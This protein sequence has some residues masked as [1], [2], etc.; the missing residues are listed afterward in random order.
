MGAHARLGLDDN[1]SRTAVDVHRT[2]RPPIEFY[3]GTMLAA[4][5][6]IEIIRLTRFREEGGAK[7]VLGEE[8]QHL[9]RVRHA[10]ACVWCH[11]ED[12]AIIGMWCLGGA[13]PRPPHAQPRGKGEMATAPLYQLAPPVARART[14]IR[15]GGHNLPRMPR[16][17]LL[18]PP[19][20]LDPT[21]A[22]SN[23]CSAPLAESHVDPS[24]APPSAQSTGAQRSVDHACVPHPCW[25]AHPPTDR[26]ALLGSHVSDSQ[27]APAA[28][29][30]ASCGQ[31]E[32][33]PVV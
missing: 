27:A 19:D 29:N 4:E 25:P 9:G 15:K 30:S 10:A 11:G 2:A 1:F 8:F 14:S 22:P 31:S 18:P 6:V 17:Q 16:L 7:R 23:E 13:A 26:A 33:T 21:S 24:T 12:I 20:G 32:P 28:G 5:A 3:E